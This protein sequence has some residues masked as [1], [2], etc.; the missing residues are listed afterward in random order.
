MVFLLNCLGLK[1][2]SQ[3]PLAIILE[4]LVVKLVFIAV[5]SLLREAKD[6][7]RDG[8]TEWLTPAEH[9][10]LDHLEEAFCINRVYIDLGLQTADFVWPRHGLACHSIGS[11]LHKAFIDGVEKAFIRNVDTLP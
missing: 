6:G 7:A 2:L 1:H 10:L 9:F 11:E 3:A 5:L 8:A 4:Q